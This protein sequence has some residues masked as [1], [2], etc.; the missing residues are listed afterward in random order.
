MLQVLW[1]SFS[2]EGGEGDDFSVDILFEFRKRPE[3]TVIIT[4][5]NDF[6]MF[7]TLKEITN[8]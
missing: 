7:A 1:C 2:R 8:W 5:K 4:V 6:L 3:L